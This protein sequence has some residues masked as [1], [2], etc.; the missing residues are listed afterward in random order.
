MKSKFFIHILP[1]LS[2]LWLSSNA[3][4]AATKRII[5]II[6]IEFFG[7]DKA[8]KDEVKKWLGLQERDAFSLE[9][10]HRQSLLLLQGYADYGMPFTQ[11]DSLTY[12][13]APDSSGATVQIF[14]REGEEV[15][16]GRLNLAGVDSA[17]AETT[18]SRF[19]TR[20]GQRVNVSSLEEDLDDALVQWENRGYPFSRFDLKSATLDSMNDKHTALGLTFQTILGPQLL[21][22]EIQIEGNTLT[23]RNVI[24]REIRIRPGDLY[25][26]EKVAN[27][28]ARLMKLGYFEQVDEPEVF[29]A[30]GNEGG[31]LLRLKE[32]NSSRFDGVLGYNPSTIAEK[33]YFT[34]LIDISLG[35][36]LGT[37]RSLLAHWQKSDRRSQDAKFHYREP[38]VAGLPMNVGFGFEQLIQDTTYIQRELALDVTL[39]LSENLSAIAQLSREETTPDSLG[40][41]LLGIPKSRT[42]NATIGLDYDTRDDR[43]NPRRGIYY[44]TDVRAGKKR[45]LGPESL[46]QELE[47]KKDVDNKQISLIVKFYAPLLRRQ[48]LAFGMQGRQ[49]RSNEKYIPI[50]DQ[51]RMGGAKSLR[52]YREFQFRGSSVAWVN[53]EYRY[54]LGRRSRVFLF[55]DGGYFS[56]ED[57]SGKNEGYKT[58]YGF[59][60]RLE[61]GLG[62][63]GIDYGLGEGDSLFN[64]KVHVGLINEF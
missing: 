22:K 38:W 33:G 47:L 10:L 29:L 56:S 28:P 51:F 26:R 17:Q 31:L 30:G 1:C 64:G 37:G 32:G 12:R 59:G 49:I 15:R 3:L 57:R 27:I 36:L 48:V 34:G 21:L 60:I 63:M 42:F 55:C 53:L 13:I 44:H 19:N 4:P 14:I 16:L 35:N 52:G 11:L 45:N 50:P 62:I 39:P 58:G 41:F 24:L 23:K 18:K 20:S 6:R 61:T 43:I 2:V 40:S 7:I 54:L 9:A 46:I 5:P 8:P 25:D